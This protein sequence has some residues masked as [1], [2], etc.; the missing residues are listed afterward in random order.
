MMQFLPTMQWF[1]NVACIPIKLPSPTVQPGTSAQCPTVTFSPRVTAACRDVA[2][3]HRVILYIAVFADGQRRRRRAK[4]APYQTVAAQ[5]T[6][7][8]TVAL[9]ATNAAFLIAGAFFHKRIR[10]LLKPPF[11]LFF[12][13]VLLWHSYK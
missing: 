13:L 6:S 10:T 1:S 8:C 2:V 5:T 12:F 7:P 3:Q 4:T 11:S 9:G